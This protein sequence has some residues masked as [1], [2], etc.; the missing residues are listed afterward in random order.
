MSESTSIKFH[1]DHFQF[2]YH[3]PKKYNYEGQ[4]L[5]LLCSLPL[6]YKNFE[7]TLLYGRE[8]ITMDVVK[9]NLFSKELMDKELPNTSESKSETLTVRGRTSKRD[10]RQKKK[11]Q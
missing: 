5:F 3:R 10:S 7:E 2:N 11:K 8:S 6:S 9:T 1:I 4:A